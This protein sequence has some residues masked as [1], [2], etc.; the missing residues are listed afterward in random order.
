MLDR[1]VPS[2]SILA[3][4]FTN[5]AAAEMRSRAEALLA[6]RPLRSW[7]ST[8][9]SFCVRLL[10]REAAAAGLDPRFQIYDETDQLGAVKEAMRA[11]DLSEK[12]HPPRRLLARISAR[13]NSG[14]GEGEEDGSVGGITAEVQAPVPARCWRQSGGPR[15]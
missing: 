12:L 11:L 3:V 5:K 15:F 7:M 13:K 9:H 6:G 14:R 8:F 4:T 2:E 10:R 1:Q